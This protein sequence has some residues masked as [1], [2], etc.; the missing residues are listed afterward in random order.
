MGIRKEAWG[1]LLRRY[2]T[3]WRNVWAV[4]KELEPPKRDRHERDFL[5]AHLEL[6][7]TPVSPLP[8]WTA[9]LIMLFAVLALVWA[10][11]GQLDIVAVAQGKTEPGGQSKVI[12]P[13]ETAEVKVI[14]VRDGQH[15]EAG[16]TLLEL[17]AVG[18]D[19][20]VTQS[21]KALHAAQLAKWRNEAL[22]AA[23]DH[24]RPPQMNKAAALQAG[25]DEA[26]FLQAQLLVSNQYQAWAAQDQQIR[27]RIRQHEAESR[28][29]NA[30]IDKLTNLGSIESKRTSD[31]NKLV[32]QNFIS[33]HAYL[34]QKSKLIENQNDLKS[35]RNQREQIKAAID[36][37]KDSRAVNTQ[38]IRRDTLDALRQAD[39]Q[40]AQLRAQLDKAQQRQRLMRLAAP[41]SGTVQQLA[42]HTIGGVVTA[43][44][45]LLVIVPDDY[46]LNV[47][48]LILNKD[49]GFVRQG[50]EAVI[51]IEAFP[52]TRYGYLTGK[53]Q[54]I[55]YDAIENEQLGLVY[56]ATIALDHDT[57]N[58]EGQPVRL[59]AGMNITAEIKTG[60]RRVLDYLLSPL[61]TKIDESLRQR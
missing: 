32:K 10:W 7:E 24:N 25:I 1:D 27:A 49:I 40:S 36:E 50:Q 29:V 30:E 52:Y 46:Q 60:K 39:E 15:V 56:A 54:T 20:D 35:K 19:A 34:E 14:H 43:A 33:N 53:V 42:T 8:Q 4:R 2:L 22:L 59:S 17:R 9:R 13:L 3:V 31:L 58:I 21:E 51:K 5:P 38:T 23:L 44:Q 41:V 18:S 6:T 57:L 28:V 11:F 45:P 37:A 55:S 47:K 12:Q 61:Q 16:E 26:D 48:A